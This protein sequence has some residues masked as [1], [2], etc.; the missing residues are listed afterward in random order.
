M[1]KKIALLSLCSFSPLFCSSNNTAY[2]SAQRELYSYKINI[3]QYGNKIDIRNALQKINLKS[4]TTTTTTDCV[5]ITAY[6]NVSQKKFDHNLPILLSRFAEVDTI[7]AVITYGLNQNNQYKCLQGF[8]I[9][10][11]KVSK[12]NNH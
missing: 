5:T 12:N 3:R 10:N 2:L 11:G 6:T 1:F 4:I 7:D 8:T 9:I